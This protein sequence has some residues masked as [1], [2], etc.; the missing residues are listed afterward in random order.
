MAMLVVGAL[1]VGVALVALA[2]RVVLGMVR[3]SIEANLPRRVEW[4]RTEDPE[5]PEEATHQ[6]ARLRG[7]GFVPVDGIRE[8]DLSPPA[9][10]VPMVSEKEQAYA[11]VI[12]AGGTMVA[13][14]VVS[15]LVAGGSLTT[16]SRIECGTLPAAPG[17]FSQIV[18][19]GEPVDLI[20]AHRRAGT[21]LAELG[22]EVRAVS[23]ATFESDFQ[24]SFAKRRRAFD[25]APMKI[26]AIALWRTIRKRN[27]H[28]VPL[29]E[30]TGALR[31]ARRV[32]KRLQPRSATADTAV[33][34]GR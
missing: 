3:R 4:R 10:F 23:V 14:D 2:M 34:V 8:V 28:L 7:L 17:L 31:L 15:M 6:L 33:G 29:T 11:T 22:V 20:P 27:P 26:A 18:A 1:A 19:D 16:A 32:G 12:V 24:A 21:A 25:R 13:I 5:F 30:Q 9:L